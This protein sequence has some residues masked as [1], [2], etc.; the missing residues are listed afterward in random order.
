MCVKC[1]DTNYASVDSLT[2]NR[3]LVFLMSTDYRKK[4]ILK[5]KFLSFTGK[6]GNTR[7]V[8]NKLYN[9]AGSRDNHA[10]ECRI[11]LRLTK[12]QVYLPDPSR[13]VQL[14]FHLSEFLLVYIHN[15]L[16]FDTWK[17]CKW[18]LYICCLKQNSTI[19]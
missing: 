10:V 6:D 18:F 11:L 4:E 15:L 5:W 19:K 14:C 9:L 2:K 16:Y 8:V 13:Y 1:S 17:C 7:S 12:S 3:M